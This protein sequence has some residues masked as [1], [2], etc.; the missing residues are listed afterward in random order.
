MQRLILVRLIL[1]I[2]ILDRL[3]LERLAAC[4]ASTST[5]VTDVLMILEHEGGDW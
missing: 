4:F 3:I 1:D 5:R 2:I